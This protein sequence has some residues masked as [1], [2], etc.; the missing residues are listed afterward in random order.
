MP[1]PPY[2]PEQA[3][4]QPVPQPVEYGAGPGTVYASEQAALDAQ[5]GIGERIARFRRAAVALGR[6][7]VGA[8]K[9]WAAQPETTTEVDNGLELIVTAEG[10]GEP[11]A[12]SAPQPPYE[13][14]TIGR[15]RKDGSA[16][17]RVTDRQPVTVETVRFGSSRNS[18]EQPAKLTTETPP[19]EDQT[20]PYDGYGPGR[21]DYARQTAANL[22]V[23][24]VLGGPNPAPAMPTTPYGRYEHRLEV[25]HLKG[26]QQI[27][28]E[29]RLAMMDRLAAMQAEQAA[30]AEAAE[31]ARAARIRE[32]LAARR[33]AGVP[34]DLVLAGRSGF[35]ENYTTLTGSNR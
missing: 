21:Y 8:V 6:R 27:D 7:A 15:H 24:D 28:V 1:Q 23:V 34:F 17:I 10:P 31:Q 19:I 12:T 2:T 20:I 3:F 4:H 26:Q 32:K 35:E 30:R 22:T 25:G 29:R 18:K 9:S 13:T 33:D 11:E 14:V 5:Q 16:T